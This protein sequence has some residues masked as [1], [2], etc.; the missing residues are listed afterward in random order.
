M[1]QNVQVAVF[2]CRQE[3]I[4]GRTAKKHSWLFTA[5]R[6]SAVARGPV[7]LF[8]F[9]FSHTF[10]H[11]RGSRKQLRDAHKKRTIVHRVYHFPRFFVTQLLFLA[12][13]LV[14]FSKLWLTRY[15]E[16][17]STDILWGWRKKGR[18]FYITIT[19]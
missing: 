2:H 10:M 16:Y 4:Y 9:S 18:R 11:S 5:A 1:A 8:L 19:A 3:W 7:I 17:L 13:A 12:G 6:F 14:R 15:V